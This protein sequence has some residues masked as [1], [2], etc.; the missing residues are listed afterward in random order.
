M[1]RARG[2]LTVG[3]NCYVSKIQHDKSTGGPQ[4]TVITGRV[5]NWIHRHCYGTTCNKGD[6][7]WFRVSYPQA[8]RPSLMVVVE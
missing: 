6:F 7:T 1:V 4:N 8:R 5:E 2:E 3:P